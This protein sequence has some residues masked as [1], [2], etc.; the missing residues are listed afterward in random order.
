MQRRWP[1]RASPH[2][3]VMDAGDAVTQ[4]SRPRTAPP[5]KS[6]DPPLAP[7]RR[8]SAAERRVLKLLVD[9]RRR[10]AVA[11]RPEVAPEIYRVFEKDRRA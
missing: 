3:S 9:Q 5:T 4:W 7:R 2:S 8:L 11:A 6:D 10:E 1:R